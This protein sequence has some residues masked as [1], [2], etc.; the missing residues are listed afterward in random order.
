MNR[1][2]ELLK[3][4]ENIDDD[5]KTVVLPMIDDI[6]FLENTLHALRKLPMIR[7]K[8]DDPS[9]QRITPASKQYKEL[10]QQ[11]NNCIK[12]IC[13]VLGKTDG[14]EGSL[15]QDGLKKLYEKYQY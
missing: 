1:K 12:I 11:Y 3:I 10:L 4:C 9:L 14:G 15:L 6:V 2:D 7:V 8:E 5:I 13:S